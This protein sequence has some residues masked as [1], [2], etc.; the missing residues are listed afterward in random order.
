MRDGTFQIKLIILDPSVAYV[1][2]QTQLQKEGMEGKGRESGGNIG[3]LLAPGIS[4]TGP[5][6]S[7][8]VTVSG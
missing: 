7:I 1:G 4:C 2:T 6:E 8:I 3:I 5:Y